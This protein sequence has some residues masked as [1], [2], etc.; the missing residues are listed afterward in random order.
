MIACPGC[1]KP[2]RMFFA[3]RE[4]GVLVVS[5]R[6]QR[7]WYAEDEIW[8]SDRLDCGHDCGGFPAKQLPLVP[9]GPPGEWVVDDETWMEEKL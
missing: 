5:H 9:A 4:N 6:R 3:N 8:L 7:I 2:T 1:G